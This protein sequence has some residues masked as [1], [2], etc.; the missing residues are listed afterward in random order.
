MSR[1]VVTCVVVGQPRGIAEGRGGHAE[2]ARLAR[3]EPG[4]LLLAAGDMLGNRYG[5][6]VGALGDENLDGIDER[7]LLA[8]VEIELGGRRRHRVGGKLDLGLVAE[9]A[10]LDELEGHVDGHH[11]GQRGRMAR[12]VG[13][14]LVQDAAGVGVDR[15]ARRSSWPRRGLRPPQRQRRGG[16]CR[17]ESRN[18]TPK[19]W[20]TAS[21]LNGH[22]LSVQR[23]R[24]PAPLASSP[25]STLWA[26]PLW[27]VFA[28]PSSLRDRGSAG[29][30]YAM[31][32]LGARLARALVKTW[33]R[34]AY[35]YVAYCDA[36]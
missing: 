2:L 35:Q 8:L 23:R 24:A 16:Q 30:S 7:D 9:P 22:S 12:L 20:P 29:P 36:A 28:A 10:L 18:A 32:K 27:G 13:G 33:T 21:I 11:L 14:A 34:R 19:P 25:L 17:N 4:E 3:H 26:A 31:V 1:A 6:V 5:D 15:P